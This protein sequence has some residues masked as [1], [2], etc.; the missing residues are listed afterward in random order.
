[1]KNSKKILAVLIVLFIF[2]ILFFS[3]V[4]LQNKSEIQSE[5]PSQI[6]EDKNLETYEEDFE[7]IVDSIESID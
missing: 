5:S 7:A 4:Q 3:F 1:M 6:S 2:G